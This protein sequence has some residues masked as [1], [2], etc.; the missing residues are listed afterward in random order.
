[1][2]C[3]EWFEKYLQKIPSEYISKNALDFKEKY[4]NNITSRVKRFSDILVS[5]FL[6][7]ITF[8]ILIISAILIKMEDNG[9]IFYIQKEQDFMNKS[10]E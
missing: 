3:S 8:P 1:M 6:L 4:L 9:P 7:I 2:T 10:S 5:V